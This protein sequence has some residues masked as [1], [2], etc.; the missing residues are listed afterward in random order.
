MNVPNIL[1]LIRLCVVPLVPLVYF[2]DLP[3]ANLWAALI[4]LLATLTDA[5]DGYI[6]RKFNLITRLGR[7]LDP[8]ADKL[9]SFCVLVCIIINEPPLFWAGAVFFIKEV[10]MGLGALVQYKK[11][12]DVPPSNILGKI[13]TAYFF[14][15]CFVIL[16]YPG[17]HETAKI[18]AISTAL[19]LNVSAFAIYLWRFIRNKGK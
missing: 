8:L 12:N 19:A 2:S 7:V 1:S 6:A 11:I 3:H 17:L 14:V 10:C 15:V 5:L 4:Y 13:S 9:M 18:I 16:V